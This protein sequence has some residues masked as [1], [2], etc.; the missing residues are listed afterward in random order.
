MV[1]TPPQSTVGGDAADRLARFASMVTDAVAM[2]N[3]AVAEIK[4]ENENEKGFET[5]D[6]AR[7]SD[8][9]AEQPGERGDA[10]R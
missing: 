8:G 2:L 6:D 7:K 9:N 3:Q 5:D 10:P 1:E 4:S